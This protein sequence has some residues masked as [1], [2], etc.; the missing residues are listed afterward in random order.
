MVL[1][2][3]GIMYIASDLCIV[4]QDEFVWNIA[5]TQQTHVTNKTKLDQ[6]NNILCCYI[7]TL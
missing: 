7:L 4:Q 6:D 1:H 2:E 3:R 5:F